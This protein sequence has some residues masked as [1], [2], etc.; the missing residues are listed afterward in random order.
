MYAFST[1][2]AFPVKFSRRYCQMGALRQSVA[3]SLLATFPRIIRSCAGPRPRSQRS[4]QPRPARSLRDSRWLCGPP[5][6]A[7]PYRTCI[8][9][10]SV[11]HPFTSASN[12]ILR[13][14]VLITATLYVLN[15]KIC[16]CLQYP[17]IIPTC[18]TSDYGVSPS[19]TILTAL[20]LIIPFAPALGP[21]SPS[22][23]FGQVQPCPFLLDIKFL[24]PVPI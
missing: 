8:F 2:P 23:C 3:S 24:Q 10:S 1:G 20:E 11:S 12:C 14:P 6:P 5:H 4:L 22:A 21:I 13:S 7:T 16:H 15:L 18:L 9:S 19:G 17:F